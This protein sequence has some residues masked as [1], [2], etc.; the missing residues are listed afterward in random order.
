MARFKVLR[1]IEHSLCLYLPEAAG[2]PERAKSAAHGG[3]IAVN[4]SG[5]IELS[6]EEAAALNRGQV[7]PLGPPAEEPV[8]SAKSKAKKS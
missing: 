8:K 6:D 3:A 4:A 2:A 5:A 1:A 7:G